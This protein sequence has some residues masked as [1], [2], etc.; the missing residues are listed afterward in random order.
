MEKKEILNVLTVLESEFDSLPSFD[1]VEL[2]NFYQQLSDKYLFSVSEYF[3][4]RSESSKIIESNGELIHFRSSTRYKIVGIDYGF[5]DF[6][7]SDEFNVLD[8]DDANLEYKGRYDFNRYSYFTCKILIDKMISMIDKTI[9]NEKILERFKVLKDKCFP[10]MGGYAA[11]DACFKLGSKY[12]ENGN[13]E[14]SLFFFNQ[15]SENRK[16][17]AAS[18]IGN[19]YKT[20]AEEFMSLK[21][22]NHALQMIDIGLKLY[23]KLSV[24]KMKN[25]LEGI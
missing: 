19:F 3:I 14:M 6:C 11:I 22:N 25:L 12:A 17:I 1:A 20:A 7:F 18:T 5:L 9:S 15:M 16:D 8:I 24:K 10:N 21:Q 13:L 4:L 23:P 2:N